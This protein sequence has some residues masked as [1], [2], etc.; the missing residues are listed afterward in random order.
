VTAASTTI[1]TAER[2]SPAP[3]R[4]NPPRP[5]TPDGPSA[6]AISLGRVNGHEVEA[7]VYP[8][9]TDVAERRPDDPTD[10]W[11]QWGQ[12]LV[13]PDGRFLSAA[14]DH[15]G[16]DGNSYLYVYDPKQR[17]ITRFA[18]VLSHVRHDDG[19]WGYGKVHAQMVA[20]R[21]GEAF[22]ATYWGSDEGLRYGG[23]YRGDQLFRLDTSTLEFEPLGVPLAKHG[24]PTLAD[25]MPR[26]RL[27][28]EAVVPTPESALGSNQ[29][30][31]FVYDVT[32]RKVTF[33]TDD[34][35]LVGFR[36]V[37]VGPDGVAY[38][39][40]SDQGLLVYEPGA[41]EL[42]VHP[43]RLPGGFLRASTQPGPDGTIYGATLDP[44]HLFALRPDGSIDDLGPAR[45][46]TASLALDREGGRL[47]Y[48]PGA[49]GSS[50][51][52]GTPLI[53]VDTQTGEQTTVAMLND[54]AEQKLGLTLG[55]SYDVA[56][57]VLRKR[58]YVGLNAGRDRDDPWGEVVLVTV[59][60]A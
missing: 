19:S 18:D 41:E 11:S 26:G 32:K 43:E 12:G 51:R 21:C 4:C 20:G 48:V 45:G 39:A 47:L 22:V 38:L 25:S 31:F 9:P 24:I 49:T 54:L 15:R 7:V 17:R 59:D 60:L 56:Y 27:Y 6:K 5:V 16:P 42:R 33:R 46:D 13:L 36:T 28:G 52:L 2:S 14:G 50:W 37:M 8:R 53:S 1:A 40:T 35:R 55:G 30:A 34:E 29:G 58:V 57:D 44:D 3:R 23:S 10:P